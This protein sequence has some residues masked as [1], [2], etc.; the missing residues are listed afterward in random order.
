MAES[1]TAGTVSGGVEGSIFSLKVIIRAEFCFSE[2]NP[3]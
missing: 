1:S 3:T 2:F